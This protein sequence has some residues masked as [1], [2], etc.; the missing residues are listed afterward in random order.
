VCIDK[1]TNLPLSH[2]YTGLRVGDEGGKALEGR[3]VDRLEVHELLDG[4]LLGDDHLVDDAGEACPGGGGGGEPREGGA[5]SAQQDGMSINIAL[6]MSVKRW[7]HSAIELSECQQDSA[8]N[9][10]QYHGTKLCQHRALSTS[11]V[12]Q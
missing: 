7:Q 5:Q 11:A 6:T 3:R 9:V 4:G 2:I 12:C 8:F 1:Q 10:S